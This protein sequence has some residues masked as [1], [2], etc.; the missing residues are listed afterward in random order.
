MTRSIGGGV[1]FELDSPVTP[2]VLRLA[3]ALGVEF[4]PDRVITDEARYYA[5]SALGLRLHL[6]LRETSSRVEGAL[7]YATDDRYHA[8]GPEVVDLDFH[9]IRLL[10]AEGVEARPLHDA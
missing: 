6:E 8:P 7:S 4:E 9:F 3:A 2:F 1:R 10:A 5:A